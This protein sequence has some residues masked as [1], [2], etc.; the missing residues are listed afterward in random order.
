M[1]F[2]QQKIAILPI[3]IPWIGLFHETYVQPTFP[4]LLNIPN[5]KIGTEKCFQ[6]SRAAMPAVF[7]S[8]GFI[9]TPPPSNSL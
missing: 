8:L 5:I 2:S 6:F 3:F 1:H 9:L 4:N 7:A